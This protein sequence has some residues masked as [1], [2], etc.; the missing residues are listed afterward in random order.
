M[1]MKQKKKMMML[2]MK[3]MMM[4]TVQ[5]Y[6]DNCDIKMLII[7]DNYDISH[8]NPINHEGV[9][10]K[11]VSSC[12][13]LILP[14]YSAVQL[15]IWVASRLAPAKF[16]SEFSPEKLP[17]PKKVRI[18]FQRS[19]FRCYNMLNFGGVLKAH[20]LP[21]TSHAYTTGYPPKCH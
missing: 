4:S 15:A 10:A 16:N 21:E 1:M 20:T 5:C 9:L 11:D 3:E 19:I 12:S 6:C 18:A 8:H 7:I 17:G 14:A 13:F 2:M